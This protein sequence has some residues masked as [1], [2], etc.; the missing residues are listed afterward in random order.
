[1]DKRTLL[2]VLS[3]SFT[4][5]LVN[6]FFEQRHQETAKEWHE[7]QKAKKIQQKQELE[8][9]IAERT[10][11]IKDLPPIVEFYADSQN[12]LYLGS[13]IKFEDTILTVSWEKTLPSKIYIK[14]ESFQI[15]YS[16]DNAGEPAL[17]EKHPDAA[18]K[19]GNLPY[20]G[21]YELQIVSLLKP[22]QITLG[23]YTDGHFSIPVVELQKLTKDL[24]EK[25]ASDT[26]KE[27]P[28]NSLVLMKTVEGYLPVAFYQQNT[29]SLIY[30]EQISGL[31]KEI[32][33]S[34][35]LGEPGTSEEKFY[36]LENSY[37]QLVFSNYGGA[38]AE[39]NLPFQTSENQK[40]VVKEIEFDRTI[41]Q[42]H[43]HNAIFPENAYYTPGQSST[44]PFVENAKG[45]FGGYYPLI[46]RNLI[47]SDEKQ[48]IR[49]L[50]EYYALNIVSEYPEMAELVYEVT[51]FTQNS[52]TFEARQ[53]NRRITKI[54]SIDEE[55][56]AP[57]CINL[58]IKIEGESRGLWLISGVPEVEW[59]SNG[60]ATAL[61][62]RMTRNNNSEVINI[63]LPKEATS[64][65]SI[66]P[67]WICNSNGFLGVIQD[68]LTDIDPGFKA[69]NIPGTVV[70]SRLVLVDE[71]FELFKAQDLPGYMLLLP[72]NSKGGTMNFR[73]FAGPFASSILKIVDRTFSDPVTGD[74]P[75]YIASQSFHGWFSFISAPFAKFLLILMQFFHSLTGSW[76][77]SIILLTVAL[78]LMLYPL[79]AWSA[80]S[81]LRMQ[82]IAPDI[83]RIQEKYKKDPKKAQLEIMNLYRDKGVNPISGCFPLLI[84]MPF[85]VGM[86]DLLKSTFELR[87]ASFIPG[88][89]DNLAAPDVLFSWNAPIFFIGTQ[90]HLLPILLGAV[91]FLQQRLMS[92][93]PKD[94]NLM[95]EQQRQQKAM[96]TMMTVVFSIMF[97]H[98]PSGL[99]IYWLSSMLLGIL[100]QWW[101]AKRFKPDTVVTKKVVKGN[102]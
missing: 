81:M 51:N 35:T 49:I 100:Q 52:I 72:L 33:K 14:G 66:Y 11:K 83:Q 59:I 50:P 96:G 29:K 13:G 76:G 27:I 4:L 44:G 79:N 82:Q 15:A 89:I 24:G 37:Q 64:F 38:L 94:P 98:F 54:F 19:I 60:P 78:R 92:P 36:V 41:A 84:Q 61:K 1:M 73:I 39:I 74:N 45:K 87:G 57:Y 102:R 23:E 75:D 55:T 77:F 93:A 43:P 2:F 12:K 8:K 9:E 16:P 20:F 48:S 3:L 67:D 31:N 65:S 97:Y 101:T 28:Q 58:T 10:A 5:F 85:L 18:I 42:D 26:H 47:H 30:L 68:P 62:Y 69:Q 91:M 80:K 32:I 6:M 88:W 21:H 99:N 46:R 22:P 90:F 95:T 53:R 7:Q 63:D 56:G 70:P 25:P 86:F 34:E 17:Y 71:E 40:S